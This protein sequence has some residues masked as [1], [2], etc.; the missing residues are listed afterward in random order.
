MIRDFIADLLADPG[1]ALL[2]TLLLLCLIMV[3]P[4]IA[5]L[6]R[7]A[8]E[9]EREIERESRRRP[10]PHGRS[11]EPREPHFG[12]APR[13]LD[14]DDE[15]EEDEDDDDEPY[16]R[17]GFGAGPPR[18][19]RA[20]PVRALTKA[21]WFGLGLAVGVGAMALNSS[22]PIISEI[23]RMPIDRG[24]EDV[25]PT[26]TAQEDPSAKGDARLPQAAEDPVRIAEEAL[27]N[28]PGDAPAEADAEPSPAVDAQLTA[29]VTGM[30][31]QLPMPIGREINLVKVDA[32][33]RMVTLAFAIQRAI[34]EA[35]YPSLQR[36]LEDRFRTGI[37]KGNDQL[38]IRAL[39]EAGV[40]F[41]VL[42]SD[43]IGKTVARLDVPP[44]YCKAG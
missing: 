5:A 33:G 3:V 30:K 19:G 10:L 40:T 43:L 39:N 26:V 37:C 20:I 25:P 34:A 1:R 41:A 24:P 8:S 35:D 9:G 4:V 15:E 18:R 6:R 29:F 21:A 27:A 7:K 11:M 42:Y 23:F 13:Y 2:A 32:S 22:M 17:G 44:S 31:A 12:P 38:G 14:D 36:T 16:R 28:L